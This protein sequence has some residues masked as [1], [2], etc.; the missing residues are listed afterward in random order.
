MRNLVALFLFLIFFISCRKA[1]EPCHYIL[2]QTRDTS[3]FISYRINNNNYVYYQNYDP[4]TFAS[5][6]GLILKNQKVFNSYYH[7][8]F[9]D[10]GWN[11]ARYTDNSTRY[12]PYVELQINDTMMVNK[13]ILT[14]IKVPQLSEILRESYKFTS[15][16][17]LRAPADLSSYDPEFF[18]SVSISLYIDDIEYSTDFLV[19]RFNFSIDSLNKYLWNDSNFNITSKQKVC[20]GLKLVTGEFNTTVMMGYISKPYKI[21]NGRFRI[22]IK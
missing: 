13:N 18:P 15:P 8:K 21:E 2:D 19:N 9:D 17:T 5:E 16:K 4:S 1:T 20:N 12:H 10:L 14:Y 6:S 3:L 22:L 7:L 11:G